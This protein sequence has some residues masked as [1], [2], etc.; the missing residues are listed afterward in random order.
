VDWIQRG[1]AFPLPRWCVRSRLHVNDSRLRRTEV[2]PI[3][4]SCRRS[5]PS[6]CVTAIPS[7]VRRAEDGDSG[8]GTARSALSV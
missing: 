8:A 1:P 6:R 2:P 4:W 3:C 7:A 5:G